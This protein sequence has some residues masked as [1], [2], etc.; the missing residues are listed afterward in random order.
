[1]NYF[2]PTFSLQAENGLGQKCEPNKQAPAT[3][4]KAPYGAISAE[5][6]ASELT[7]A[8]VRNANSI[9]NARHFGDGFDD[10]GGKKDPT[11]K[12]VEPFWH[13]QRESNP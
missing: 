4:G 1:M 12:V 8:F 11:T 9:Q 5:P 6:Y 2:C 7:T 13:P 3:F 10:V